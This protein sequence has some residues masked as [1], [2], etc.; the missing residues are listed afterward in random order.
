MF[1][2]TFIYGSTDLTLALNSTVLSDLTEIRQIYFSY[3]T[4]PINY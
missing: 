2:A 4:K 3:K 1:Y